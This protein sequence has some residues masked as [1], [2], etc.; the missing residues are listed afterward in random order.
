MEI[1]GPRPG[2]SSPG[3]SARMSRA[4][5]RDTKPE[6]S[7]RRLLHAAG[8]RYRVEYPVPGSVRRSVDIAFTR[9]KVAVFL[10]GCFWHACPQHGTTPHANAA[11][12]DAKLRGNAARDLETRRLLEAQGWL[13]LRFWE[14]EDPRLVAEQVAGV[15]TGRRSSDQAM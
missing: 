6:V 9:A 11:W 10:D 5:R 1:G 7:V 4:R 2:A 14:H 13:V 3:V 8:L 15:V 12:W